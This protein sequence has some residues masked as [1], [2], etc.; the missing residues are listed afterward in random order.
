MII[1]F[2]VQY[3]D[4]SLLLMRIIVAL[5]FVSSGL[6]DLKDPANRARSME[7]SV[8]FT[9]FLGVAEILGG[10]GLMFG[11]LTQFAALGLIIISL[12]AIKKK[13]IEWKIGFWG[14]GVYGWHYD[15][16]FIVMN[17]VILI[18]SGGKYI[19]F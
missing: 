13:V 3:V 5:V 11:I 14:T 18:T 17:L 6:N 16:L 1:N 12:G 8:P 15:L 19:L 4:V 7:V 2:P 10:I 9:I